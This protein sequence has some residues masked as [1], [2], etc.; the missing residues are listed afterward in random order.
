MMAQVT[1]DTDHTHDLEVY[2][3]HDPHACDAS[4]RVDTAVTVTY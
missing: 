2:I 1:H 3:T 4:L